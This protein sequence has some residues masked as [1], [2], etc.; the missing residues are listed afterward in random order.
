MLRRLS[1]ASLLAI[2]I[3]FPIAA[4]ATAY[5]VGEGEDAFTGDIASAVA[6]IKPFISNI[7]TDLDSTAAISADLNA[8]IA[9][10]KAGD[11]LL[12]QYAGHGAP[13]TD[14]DP[15][16][17]DPNIVSVGMNNLCGCDVNVNNAD[18]QIGLGADLL[19]GKGLTDDQLTTILDKVPAGATAYVVL[20]ACF[21]GLAV[22]GGQDLGSLPIDFIGTADEVHCAPAASKFLPLFTD[23]FAL[24][25]GDF[26]ADS[27]HNGVLTEGELFD[28]TTTF[29][30][31][32]N[33]TFMQSNT[34]EDLPVAFV[35]EPT[36]LA[37][38]LGTSGLLIAMRRHA[39]R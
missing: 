4:Q 30:G 19:A 2:S 12:F 37:L 28:Y 1:L 18:E 15:M 5:Y 16:A 25:D 26:K 20:D 23:A 7:T 36:T 21:A 8:T 35:S 14:P 10:M 31:P 39:A 34:D 29:D 38:L 3:G 17:G 33:P 9:K 24:R 11:V 6:A 27:N 22:S 32:E 13:V